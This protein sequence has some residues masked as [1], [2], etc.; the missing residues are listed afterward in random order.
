MGHYLIRASYTQAGIQGVL[1]D[2]GT[3]RR[4]AI[5]A[6]VASVGGTIESC[7]W[8]LGEDDILITVELPDN[9]AAAA[10]AATVGASGAA[11]ITTTVLLT[12]DEVDAAVAKHPSYRAPGS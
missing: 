5:D 8:A 7:Y 1:K 4:T 11:S 10:V 3:G 2:G 6:L 9:V 12:A